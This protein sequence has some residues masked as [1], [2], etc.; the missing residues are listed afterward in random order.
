VEEEEDRSRRGRWMG[1][2]RAKGVEE[3]KAEEARK[4]GVEEE[5]GWRWG[6]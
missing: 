4:E 5:D 3:E 1:L 2:R 6:R